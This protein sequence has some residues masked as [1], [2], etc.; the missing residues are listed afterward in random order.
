MPIINKSVLFNTPL[1]SGYAVKLSYEFVDGTVK[2]LKFRTNSISDAEAFL[3]SKEA[4][5]LESKKN[6]DLDH[7][8]Q[9]NSDASTDDTTQL[10]IYKAWM[11]KGF[12]SKD[13][14]EAYTYLVK[15]ADKVTDLGL[16]SQ[17]L[18]NAFNETLETI[19]LVLAKWQYLKAN[20]ATLLD[21]KN[22]KGNM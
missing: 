18:A 11:F 8:I 10:E 1:A 9:S 6:Q 15:V 17:Q 12:K 3:I 16:T 7:Q 2:T 22:I 20:K 19:Q 21:Y 13:P 14:I 5:V 4:N